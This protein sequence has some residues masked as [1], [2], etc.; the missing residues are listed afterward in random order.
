[1]KKLIAMLAAMCAAI[2][3]A[4]AAEVPSSAEVR[5]VGKYL[6]ELTKGDRQSLSQKKTTKEQYGDALIGYAADEKKPAAKFLPDLLSSMKAPTTT[7]GRELSGALGACGPPRSV[8]HQPGSVMFMHISVP[9][10]FDARSIVTLSRA[11]LLAEYPACSGSKRIPLVVLT[12]RPNPLA[13]ILGR[14]W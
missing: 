8:R 12:M 10:Y 14:K 4:L 2:T 6:D 9:L 11:A 13:S 1:M 7:P 5:E 3:V